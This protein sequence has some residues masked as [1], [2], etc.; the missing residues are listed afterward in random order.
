MLMVQVGY[1]AHAKKRL[2]RCET[3]YEVKGKCIP[4]VSS[5]N[6]LGLHW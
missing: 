6:V 1:H 3:V 4:M 2:Q 5:Y